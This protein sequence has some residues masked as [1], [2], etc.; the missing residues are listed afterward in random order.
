MSASQRRIASI[1]ALRGLAVLAV[2]AYHGVLDADLQASPWLSGVY[3]GPFSHFFP[4]HLGKLGV[5]LFF[6]ISGFCIHDAMRAWCLAHPGA[7]AGEQWR[8]Y[9]RRRFL[10]IYPIY[11]ATLVLVFL[12]V[13]RAP[14][15]LEG[16]LTLLVHA[17][18]LQTLLPGHVNQVNPSLWSLAVEVQ[19]YALYPLLWMGMHR[20]GARQARQVAVLAG[21]AVGC[22]AWAIW[23]PKLTY[24]WTM[25][26]LPW[27][28]GFEWLLGVAV[29]EL[30]ARGKRA[31]SGATAACG[32]MALLLLAPSRNLALFV[33]LPPIVFAFLVS[34]ASARQADAIVAR[35]LAAL[36]RI[37]YPF[38]LIHQP[39]I[40]LLDGAWLALAAS[41]ACAWGLE[42]AARRFE[43]GSSGPAMRP[44]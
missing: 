34:W 27:R 20:P 38:Y 41:I 28:W 2:F 12:A 9:A 15:S 21:A 5:Q 23:V 22:L 6:V 18:L 39:L 29:A 17:S 44:A 36:G 25:L 35:A 11:A 4:H 24:D 30:S 43:R 19:L 7:T 40:A 33:A 37:S 10:R 26:H 16:T 8:S 1:D 31:G 3:G 32:V 42:V 13:H 14:F